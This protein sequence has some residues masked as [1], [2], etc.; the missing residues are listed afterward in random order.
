M[1]HLFRFFFDL[2]IYQ[3]APIQS[4]R[5]ENNKEMGFMRAALDIF[6]HL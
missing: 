6:H 4:R 3:Y 2:F 5:D 1:I